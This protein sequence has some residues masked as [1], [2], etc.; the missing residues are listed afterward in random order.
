MKLAVHCVGTSLLQKYTITEYLIAEK[1]E[2]RQN[3]TCMPIRRQIRPELKLKNHQLTDMQSPIS[4]ELRTNS[5]ID[6]D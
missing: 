6:D 1:R 4:Y 3:L 5:A 2:I